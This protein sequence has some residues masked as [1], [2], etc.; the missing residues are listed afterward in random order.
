MFGYGLGRIINVVLI[1]GTA[2]GILQPAFSEQHLSLTQI[3]IS[4]FTPQWTQEFLMKW[5][6]V[7]AFAAACYTFFISMWFRNTPITIIS[8][9]IDVSFNNA[10]GSEVEIY[11]EQLLRANEPNV[12]AY[13]SAHE[14]SGNG[15]VPSDRIG[16]SASCDHAEFDQ[17]FEL[18]VQGGKTELFHKFTKGLPYKWYMPLMPIWI[19]NRD[20]RRL[21]WFLR[22]YVVTRTNSVVY[23]NEY[24]V[25]KPI[26]DFAAGS[27]RYHQYNTLIRLNFKDM[28]ADNVRVMRIKNSG[29]TD[30]KKD[31]QANGTVVIW[32]ETIR[33]ETIRITW[34]PK[35][36]NDRLSEGLAPQVA[37]TVKV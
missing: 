9:K 5:L 17:S 8:S 30:V 31:K 3:I 34:Q 14:A 35:T 20:Y 12:T 28:V 4:L 19:L 6:V 23:I 33:M 7:L 37:A 24:N 29:V 1:V 2:I 10:D 21:P 36:M 27:G 26:M 16:V 11:R 32:I 18:F 25:E 22:K 15:T 13:F